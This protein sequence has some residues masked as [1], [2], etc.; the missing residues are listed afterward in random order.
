M[1]QAAADPFDSLDNMADSLAGT[2]DLLSQMAGKEV[3]RL[4]AEHEPEAPP[5]PEI[6]PPP[7]APAAAA[8][9]D[10]TMS[11]QLD[12]LFTEL[13]SPAGAANAPAPAA[14]V[15]TRSEPL[16]A[17]P[18]RAALLEAAGFSGPAPAGA[19]APITPPEGDSQDP[20]SDA[21][22]QG[23]ERSALLKAAGFEAAGASAAPPPPGPTDLLEPAAPAIAPPPPLP[24]YLRP[25]GWISAPLDACPSVVRRIVG[26]AA[27]VTLVN[28]L[29]VLT[30]VLMIRRH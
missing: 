21:A 5:V 24:G 27:V 13:E 30:Y 17:G 19:T 25:L 28:A 16:T 8:P 12:Q 10:Q 11:S 14:S 26:I 2:D 22:P 23:E 6:V 20:I 9:A 15:D 4:L 3:D 29:A 1:A 7:P 18:E